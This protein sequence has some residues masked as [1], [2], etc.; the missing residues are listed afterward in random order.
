MSNLWAELVAIIAW[1]ILLKI[2]LLLPFVSSS[3]SSTTDSIEKGRWNPSLDGQILW[4]N[5]CKFDF[6]YVFSYAVKEP[7]LTADECGK[8]CLNRPMTCNHFI[9]SSFHSS[10]EGN[11]DLLW[12]TKAMKQLEVNDES[13]KRLT[14]GYIQSQVWPKSENDD[15]ILVKF[16][17]TFQSTA[18]GERKPANSFHSCKSYCLEDHLCSAFS[19][20]EKKKLCIMPHITNIAE[21][22][23]SPWILADLFRLNIV[24]V[25][26][27]DSCAI[28]SSRSWKQHDVST[29]YQYNCDFKNVGII[30]LHQNKRRE[31]CISQ[32]SN[33]PNCT[34]FSFHNETCYLKNLPLLTAD[35]MEVEGVTC[36]YIPDKIKWNFTTIDGW[37]IRWKEE[38]EFN[39]IRGFEANTTS[40]EDCRKKCVKLAT[41]NHFSHDGFTC[42][43]IFNFQ[44]SELTKING[45]QWT[46]GYVPKR[47]WHK[48]LDEKRILMKT[49]CAFPSSS[50]NVITSLLSS[51]QNICLN[52]HLCNAF[53][54]NSTDGK[55]FL[56]HKKSEFETT[57]ISFSNL[58][59]LFRF[60]GRL[61]VD[62]RTECG[63]IPTRNWNIDL[64]GPADD[65]VLYQENCDF[66][67]EFDIQEPQNQSSLN[68]CIDHCFNFTRC[69]HFT[70]KT[71]NKMCSVKKA[72][73]FVDRLTAGGDQH[74]GYIPSRWDLT[75]N[76]TQQ[77]V[78]T[79]WIRYRIINF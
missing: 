64:I 45:K 30:G 26:S 53:S 47:I 48:A 10:S 27:S 33:N 58:T 40:A 17:C 37:V 73:V 23:S 54:Y 36:G 2:N 74:C 41:C 65:G 79:D 16:N 25:S 52:D 28:V 76:N 7:V 49:E 8:H 14:C 20:S 70:Y 59:Q 1:L 6:S 12:A 66:N 21:K 22:T 13:I 61:D 78:S 19:Y 50:Y 39:A 77:N 38:C 9:F 55:C 15:Q 43:L 67:N 35:R 32:C 18:S 71:N 11:C 42:Y 69:T 51:C 34:H 56:P 29:F 24:N 4:R 62:S 63:F 72:S 46:C 31:N 3:S 75:E 5:D 44:L 68:D 60:A 57:I